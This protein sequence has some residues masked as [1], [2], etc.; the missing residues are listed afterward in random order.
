MFL[1]QILLNP[2]K[3]VDAVKI[4]NIFNMTNNSNKFKIQAGVRECD[5]EQYIKYTKDKTPKQ[6]I[7]EYKLGKVGDH[8]W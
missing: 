5:M 8:K 4:Q 2:N 3:Y 1:L 7:D 6:I